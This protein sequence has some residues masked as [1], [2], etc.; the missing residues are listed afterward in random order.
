M[1]DFDLEMRDSS[2]DAKSNQLQ[3]DRT[4]QV[5]IFTRLAREFTGLTFRE[6][7]LGVCVIVGLCLG[8]VAIVCKVLM[9]IVHMVEFFRTF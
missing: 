7:I 2:L 1:D 6:K 5:G 8:A 4:P 3:P 9:N